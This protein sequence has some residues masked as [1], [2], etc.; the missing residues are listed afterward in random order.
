MFEQ[1]TRPWP[2]RAAIALFVLGSPLFV[3]VAYMLVVLFPLDT[4]RGVTGAFSGRDVVQTAGSLETGVTLA[5]LAAVAWGLSRLLRLDIFRWVSLS[6]LLYGALLVFPIILL[7]GVA[8]TY[9]LEWILARRGYD[10]CTLHVLSRD[11]GESGV[12]AYVRHDQPGACDK[13][14]AMFPAHAIVDGNTG[15]FDLPPG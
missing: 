4:V 5:L 1:S 9:G 14:K 6:V 2:R 7:S 3:L 11:R 12:S 13:V 8:A 15:A 10:Y